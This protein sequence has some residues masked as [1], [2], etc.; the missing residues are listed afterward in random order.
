MAAKSA[1]KEGSP[2]EQINVTNNNLNIYSNLAA[3]YAKICATTLEEPSPYSKCLP[4]LLHALQWSKDPREFAE[5]LPHL[6]HSLNLPM[7]LETMQT[8]GFSY[9]H[10]NSE[11]HAIDPRLLPCLF[12]AKND[13][14]GVLLEQSAAG[15]KIYNGKLETYVKVPRKQKIFGTVYRFYAVENEPKSHKFWL[16]YFIAQKKWLFLL[17]LITSFF[18][19]V[20]FLS[21]PLFI[22]SV[23]NTVIPAKSLTM[24]G[25]LSIGIII[26]M[27][28]IYMFNSLRIVINSYVV[29][30][31]DKIASNKIFEHLLFLPPKS[32]LN[33][34]VSAQISR[35]SDFSSA[36]EF[37]GGP[38]LALFFDL[39]YVVLFLLV[40]WI[41]GGSL[42]VVPI[43]SIVIFVLLG[44]VIVPNLQQFI[45]Q[46][47]EAHAKKQKF[48]LEALHKVQVVKLMGLEDKW[49]ERFTEFS[50]TTSQTNLYVA[51]ITSIMTPLADLVII[52][53]GISL[54]GLG[55]LKALDNTMSVGAI[56]ASLMLM[57]R[58]LSPIKN[59][60][61]SIA[62]FA[63][64]YS[65]LKQ[66]DNFMNLPSEE[67]S[68]KYR[69]CIQ[70]LSGSIKFK[71][72]SMH[73]PDQNTLALTGCTFRCEPGE[74]IAITGPNGAG[75]STLFNLILGLFTPQSGSVCIDDMDIRQVDNIELR[76][77][78]AHV[79]QALQLFYG[80]IAQNMRFGN[81]IAT[82]AELEE[83]AKLAGIYD[84]IQRLPDKFDFRI[85]DQ[86]RLSLSV[87][88]QKKM[89]LARAYAKHSSILLLDEP[90]DALDRP[91]D[92]LLLQA[93]NKLRGKTTI[94]LI[95]HRPSHW[96]VAD[97][98]LVM[99][100]GIVERFGKA[101]E[102]IKFLL[103][104]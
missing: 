78:I 85:H 99:N 79:P 61:S 83:A 4:I 22:K 56:I 43:I 17:A 8:L 41:L 53:T 49:I 93:I 55:V 3:I 27:L 51:I 98:I 14:T 69:D 86:D 32:T 59:S 89:T 97:K 23:Y 92:E 77:H 16:G 52:I 37:I 11:L 71:N 6:H 48:L 90:G 28:G 45:L 70:G 65:S 29:D 84:E 26:S 30:S 50:A 19:N 104:K 91:G 39:P 66:V 80:T 12:I 102:M 33:S 94:L 54:I 96:R 18:M 62:K 57:W 87:S 100:E 76:R 35:L 46:A 24:L 63:Q 67:A 42:V 7:F 40:I 20:L 34:N 5:A 73:Y 101:E 75:K 103:R 10:F 15:T 9:N 1:I 21:V 13:E 82:Q 36:L 38:V 47:S 72:V 58:V 60:F 68:S 25:L 95:T 2:V 81:P 64:V 88:F 31:I 74:V 44:L